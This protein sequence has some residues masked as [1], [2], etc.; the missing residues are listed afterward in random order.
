M[1]TGLS[2]VPM[3]LYGAVRSEVGFQQSPVCF[4]DGDGSATIII[5]TLSVTSQ[6]HVNADQH[7]ETLTRGGKE[8]P[9]VGAYC[10]RERDGRRGNSWGHTCPDGLK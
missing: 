9:H 8:R 3:E 7:G 6:R 10:L 1:G 4:Q 2:G 5:G